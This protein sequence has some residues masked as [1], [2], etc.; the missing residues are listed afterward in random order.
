MG[1][2]SRY[3]QEHEFGRRS[4]SFDVEV[5]RGPVLFTPLGAGDGAGDAAAS[6]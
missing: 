5:L 2:R 3:P 6:S 1:H 4:A